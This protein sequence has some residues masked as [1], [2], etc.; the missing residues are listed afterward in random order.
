MSVDLL[1]NPKQSILPGNAHAYDKPLCRPTRPDNWRIAMSLI[2]GPEP[3]PVREYLERNLLPGHRR[4]GLEYGI[5]MLESQIM[6]AMMLVD[7]DTIRRWRLGKAQLPAGV[8]VYGDWLT[9]EA[10]EDVIPTTTWNPGGVGV[11]D[12]YDNVAGGKVTVFEYR[13]DKVQK[14]D[15]RDEPC[16]EM[17]NMVTFHCDRCHTPD[18]IDIGERIPNTRPSDRAWTAKKARAH[19]RGDL[20]CERPNGRIEQ[21]ATAVM[22]EMRGTAMAVPSRASSC[23]TDMVGCGGVRQATAVTARLIAEASR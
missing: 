21:V 16:G 15:D 12:V 18:H 2:I 7:A 23:A 9:E 1:V 22:S 19:A 3:G 17:V 8:P 10:W 4:P 11:L 6:S 13:V 20:R 14:Y 5:A